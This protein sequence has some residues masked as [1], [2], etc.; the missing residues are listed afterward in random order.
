MSFCINPRANALIAENRCSCR[1]DQSMMQIGNTV[2][3]AKR[4]SP[5]SCSRQM[6][7]ATLL[8][9]LLLL[10]ITT[11]AMPVMMRQ[12]DEIDSAPSHQLVDARL[13]SSTF[14]K[15]SDGLS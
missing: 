1:A 3:T 12:Q 10:L 9:L 14:G 7:L 11:R 4:S 13:L 2:P 15:Q 5:Y 8:P 6:M